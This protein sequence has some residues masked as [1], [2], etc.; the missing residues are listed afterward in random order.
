MKD[1]KDWFPF[2]ATVNTDAVDMCLSVLVWVNVF[3]SLVSVQSG[4]RVTGSYSKVI[5]TISQVAQ[6]VK[7]VPAMQDTQVRSLGQEEPLEEEMATHSSILAWRIPQTEEPG[8][9]QS[10]ESQT[11]GHDRATNCEK[12][13]QS[14][15]KLP[16]HFPSR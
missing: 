14:L 3:I 12:L 9:L 2:G 7:N 16:H 5:V 15:P 10:T 11:G 13:P 8:G 6:M 1:S 4:N